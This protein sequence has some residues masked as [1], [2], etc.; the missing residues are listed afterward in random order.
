MFY[1]SRESGPSMQMHIVVSRV[2]PPILLRSLVLMS[3]MLLKLRSTVAFVT[4]RIAKIIAKFDRLGK[5]A[6]MSTQGHTNLIIC[7]SDFP[8][9]NFPE[10]K[11]KKNLPTGS[12][13]PPNPVQETYS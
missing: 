6:A 13:F 11:K 9:Q 5:A 4:G 2:S 1:C 3:F 12:L 8:G 10:W 7:F